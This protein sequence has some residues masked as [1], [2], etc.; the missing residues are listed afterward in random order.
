MID[1]ISAEIM[2]LLID[3]LYGGFKAGLSFA[4]AMQLFIATDK[5]CICNA[6]LECIRILETHMADM[7]AVLP[8]LSSLADQHHSLGLQEV[9]FWLTWLAFCSFAL[10]TAHLTCFF[11]R[12]LP[13]AHLTCFL[14]TW[15]AFCSRPP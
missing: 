1:D 13:A 9:S 3:Y 11:P 8:V 2:Q 10:D 14:L 5:Y 4:Q 7:P 15:L 12:D 6:N